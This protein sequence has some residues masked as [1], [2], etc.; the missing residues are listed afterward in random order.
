MENIVLNAQMRAKEEK[1]KLLRQE[2]IVPANVYGKTQEALSLKIDASDLLRAHR[3]AWGSHI[4]TLVIDDKEIEVLFQEI[5]REP[6]SGD[7]IHADFY[8]LTRGE[9]L[10]TKIPLNFIGNSPAVKSGALLNENVKEIEVSCLPRDLVDAFDVDLGLLVEFDSVIR[11]SDLAIDPAMYD[12][13]NLH[14][15]DAVAVASKPKVA[16]DLDAPIADVPVT[17]AD[18]PEETED[19]SDDKK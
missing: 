5:Q 6:V 1:V 4:V 2:R 9:K 10:T 12:I 15:E 8:A 19:K 14:P 7:I 17:W 16:E 3:N 18:T 11:I 13:H